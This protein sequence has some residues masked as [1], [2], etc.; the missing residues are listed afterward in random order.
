[1]SKPNQ[2]GYIPKKADEVHRHSGNPKGSR[3]ESAIPFFAHCQNQIIVLI[4]KCWYA[5][6]FYL[7]LQQRTDSK[8]RVVGRPVDFVGGRFSHEE[9]D[10]SG[11]AAGVKMS[12]GTADAMFEKVSGQKAAGEGDLTFGIKKKLCSQT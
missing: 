3:P 1:M 7:T 6:G 5:H 10:R 2:L 8:Q 9:V 12:S 4:H 11:A